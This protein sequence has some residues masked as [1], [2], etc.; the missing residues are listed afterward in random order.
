[1]TES[2]GPDFDDS[3]RERYR[4]KKPLSARPQLRVGEVARSVA[5]TS[6]QPPSGN[7]RIEATA[8]ATAETGSDQT[9]VTAVQSATR[10]AVRRIVRNS[11]VWRLFP[12]KE[13]NQRTP[14]RGATG[15]TG[16]E[17]LCPRFRWFTLRPNAP[18]GGGR[19]QRPTSL[20]SHSPGAARTSTLC[21]R[22][23]VRAHR[24]AQPRKLGCWR[25]PAHR[26]NRKTLAR[27]LP[28]AD[29]PESMPFVE[30]DVALNPRFQIRG[31]TSRARLGQHRL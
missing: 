1:V 26:P 29:H 9:A 11:R 20:P 25:I 12:L 21:R 2:N 22:E 17:S 24:L 16:P 10:W 8:E 5:N 30:T 18:R 4:T 23:R 7:R 19:R 13:R 14:R 3:I 15:A 6:R 27:H 31:R 28:V